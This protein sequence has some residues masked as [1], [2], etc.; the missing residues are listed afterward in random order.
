MTGN[1]F[2]IKYAA[3]MIAAGMIFSATGCYQIKMNM[4]DAS[5]QKPSNVALYFSMD[6]KH[7]EPVTN[8]PAEQFKIYEDGK[9]I[10]T[11][12]SK[13]TMLNQEV[14]IERYTLLLLDMSG[15]VVD[16]GQVPLVQEAVGAFLENIGDNEKIAIYAFDGRKDLIPI[17]KFGAREA[18]LER[19][20]ELLSK[21]EPKDSSTNLNG[22]IVSAVDELEKAKE[23]SRV[24]LRFGTL[25]I[26]TD[27]TDRA[28]RVS[29]DDANDAISDHDLTSFVIGL[30]GEVDNAQ[31][32]SFGKDGFVHAD[33]KEG[34]VESFKKVADKINAQAMRYYLLS[35]CSPSRAGDH[36]LTVEVEIEGQKG[37][38]KYQFNAD[39][40]KPKC[41]PT[42]APKFKIPD[43]EDQQQKVTDDKKRESKNKNKVSSKK[44]NKAGNSSIKGK[45]S[46]K[47]KTSNK[48]QPS[49]KSPGKGQAS[50]KSG[51]G[52][53]V[54]PPPMP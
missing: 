6:D 19:K 16:S 5:V 32:E 14:A 4:V 33:D 44:S 9:L 28:H 37:R 42:D 1:F 41:D 45:A 54:P 43:P 53:A 11:Y 25:V 34:I 52:G 22:A 48:N 21:Y 15:S 10:S 18:A 17:A 8:V 30:G 47:G 35:Y 2:N 39:N 12:E 49:D 24:P 29:V 31:M 50:H 36:E 26:F 38:L 13:Q 46:F 27:G 40:F 3:L 23:K 7:S 51:G 20:N